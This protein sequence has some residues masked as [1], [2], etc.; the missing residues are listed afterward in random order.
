MIW[1]YYSNSLSKNEC[2]FFVF[3]LIL[4]QKKKWQI[5]KYF[6]IFLLYTNSGVVRNTFRGKAK[7]SYHSLFVAYKYCVRFEKHPKTLFSVLGWL[8]KCIFVE[9]GKQQKPRTIKF[10]ML[11]NDL[12]ISIIA[13]K[14]FCGGRR[15]RLMDTNIFR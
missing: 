9:G 8:K 11:N 6:L 14:H 12:L 15:R 3:F 1:K 5:Y 2:F 4:C 10:A 13:H 7:K